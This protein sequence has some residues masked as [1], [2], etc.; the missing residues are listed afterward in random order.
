M[1]RAYVAENEAELERMRA[2]VAGLDEDGLAHPT[3]AGWTVASVLAHL[4]F[5]D[6]RV[7]AMLDRWA[8]DG[9]GPPPTDEEDA[10][11]IN[12]ATKPIFLA[13][14]PALAARIA[15]EAAEASDLAVAAMSDELLSANEAMGGFIYPYR[16]E[17]R[18][19]H[20]DELE[21]AIAAARSGR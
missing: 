16:V 9:S 17:H 4:A 11:W 7:V 10:D 5:W 18:R 3:D 15:L 13:L 19:E 21:Q 2:F 12:D 14:P 1:D 6:Y 20:L 8:P